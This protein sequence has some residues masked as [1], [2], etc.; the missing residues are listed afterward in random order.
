VELLSYRINGPFVEVSLG[1]TY[2]LSALRAL[3]ESVRDDPA[4]PRG[5][6][7]LFDGSARTDVLSDADVRARLDA[8]LE[9]LAPRVAPVCAVI[10]S[11]AIA[12]AAQTAQ[13]EARAADFRV[14]LFLDFESARRWLAGY[15]PPPS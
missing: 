6:L 1:D 3:F 9:T 5:A 11:S 7:L 8:L 10:M 12:R 15:L 4:L 14:E 2:S 13:R